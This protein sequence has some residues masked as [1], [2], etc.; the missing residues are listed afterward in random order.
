MAEQQRA[1]ERETGDFVEVL[2]NEAEVTIDRI[3]DVGSIVKD[4]LERKAS[5]LGDVLQYET[6]VGVHAIQ[7]AE[8]K[9]LQN[10][11]GLN[12]DEQTSFKSDL[13]KGLIVYHGTNNCS[14][15]LGPCLNLEDSGLEDLYLWP[16]ISRVILQSIHKDKTSKEQT[17]EPLSNLE[18]LFSSK[19][20]IFL[21]ADAGV[22]KTSFCKFLVLS[23]CKV[24]EGTT[25]LKSTV[26]GTQSVS[27]I[28]EYLKEFTYLFYINLRENQCA[29]LEDIIFSH[30]ESVDTKLT[31]DNK[32]FDNILSKENGLFILDGLDECKIPL[33][34]SMPVNRKYTV[35]ITSRPWK[36]ANISMQKKYTHAQIEVMKQ[37]LSKQLVNHANECLNKHFK[38]SYDTDDFL[39]AVKTQ[40]LESQLEN[41]MFALQLLC[42]YHDK[43]SENKTCSDNA[44]VHRLCSDSGTTSVPRQTG[45]TYLGKT[46]SH[47]YANMIELMLRSTEKK[48]ESLVQDLSEYYKNNGQ[49]HALPEC[50]DERN[51]AC[52]G[53]AKLIYAIGKLAAYSLL[54]DNKSLIEEHQ[55][56]KLKKDETSV[57]LKSGLLSKTSLKTISGESN[58]YT[59]LHQ[60]Y[61]EMLACVFLSS[62]SFDSDIWRKFIENFGSVVSPDML[63]FLC[64]MNYEQGCKCVDMFNESKRLFVR[65]GTFYTSE[66]IAYQTTIAMTHK[67]CFDNGIKEP[68]ITLKH[69]LLNPDSGIGT[70]HALLHT[71]NPSSLE[72]FWVAVKPELIQE[73]PPMKLSFVG[74]SQFSSNLKKLSLVHVN[75]DVPLDLANCP[76]LQKLVMGNTSSDSVT[77]ICVVRSMQRCDALQELQL[78]TLTFPADTHLDL[79]GLIH[80]S[81]I[82][83]QDTRLSRVTIN[84]SSLE[85]FWVAVK[86]E[87]IQEIPPMKL[88]FVGGSQFSSNLKKL[89]L[90]H[91]N[92]DV[93]LDLAN[94]PQLQKLVMGNTSSDS[95]TG[96]CV[97]RSMQRCDA[98]QELQLGTLTFPADTH[99]DLS[100]LTHLSNITIQDTRLSRVTINPSSLEEFC[101]YVKPEL[102]QEIPPMKLSFVG[103]SQFSSNLKKLSLVHVNMDVPLDLANCPQLQKLVMGNTSSDSVTGICVVRS[104][105]R[106][107]ALQKLQLGTLTF[108]ADTHLDLSGLTHLSNITIQHTRLSH[109]TIN[110]SCLEMFWVAVKPELIQEIPPVKLSFVGGSQF[111]SNLKKLS[112][113]HVNMDVPLDLANCPQ[114]QE[115]VM[116]NTSSDSVTG[117]CVVRSMQR[118]D[119]LQ[120][121]Q[122]DTLTFPADTHLDL[123]GLTH[124]SNITIQ[125]TRLSRVTI[126]PSS[127]EEF[128]VYVKPELIQEIPPMKLSFVGGSQFSSNLKKLSLVHVNMDVPLDLANCPQ[129]QELV[130]ENTSS[131]SVTGICVVRSMQRCD[132]LQKLRLDTLTFPADTHLDL[133]G[134]THLSNITIQHTRLSHVTINP[135]CLE[136]FWV[137]VK[138]ELIQ[139]I[140]PVKLSFVGGSQ[141]S[142]N[143]KKLSLVHVNMDVPL[144]LANCPQLQKLVMENTS[145]D[146]V[147]GI[148]VVRSM[149]RCDALQEL[150]L[151]TLTFPADTHLDLSGLTH[152]SN[153]TIQDTRLS[154]VTINPSSLE[155]FCVYVK[156]E[157]IQEI[158]PM[159]L[160][161]VGGSQFSSNLKKL[162]L[163][164]VNM[165]VPLDLANCPQLQELVMENTSSDS[166]TGICVVRSMQRCDALQ[167]LRLDTLTFPADTHLD[168]SG[169]T[170]LS[171]ITIQHTRLSHV[172]INPSCLEVLWVAV[173]PELIQEIPPVKLSFVGGSQFSSNLKKLSLVHVNMDVPL[174]LANCPQ[175][176]KLVM[177]NTSSDSVTGICVVRSMQRCDALQ[178]LRLDT[179]TFPADTHLDLSGFTHLSSITIQDTR[180]SRITIN[181]SSLEEFGVYVRPE[182]IQEIPPMKLS[183][184]GGSQFSSNLK[185]L[186]LVHVTMDVPLDLAN[187]PQLQQV[188]GNTSS[189]SVTGI[190]VVRSM[191]RCDA[192]H[193]LHLDTLTFPA[194]T[195]LD[196]SGLTHI[197]NIAIQNTRLSRVTINPSSLEKF[198]VY[199][200]PELIQEI[201]PVKLSFVGGSQFSSN[202]KKL[203]LVHVTM[204]VPLDLAN[205]P[206]LQQLVMENTSS[207]SVTGICVVRSMQRCDALQKL[208]LNTLTFPADTHLDLSELTCLT[209]ISLARLKTN[210]TVQFPQNVHKIVIDGVTFRKNTHLDLSGLAH[211]SKITIQNTRLSHV[212]INPSSLEMFWVYVRPEMRQEIP[213]MKVSFVGGLQ[214][215][216]NLKELSLVNVTMDVP[217]DLANCQQLHDL[218]TENTSSDSVTGICVVRSMQRCDALQKLQLNTLTFPADTH[219]DLS[220]LTCLTDISLARLK[221]NITVQFPQNVH[222][223]FIDGVI[224]RTNTHLDLSGLAHLSKI[225]IQNIRLSRVTINPSCLEEFWVFVKPELKQEIPSMKLSFVGGS[226][227]PSNLK[228]LSLVHVIMDAPLDLANC[229]Q[230]QKLVMENTSSDSVTDICVV[231]NMQRCDALQKLRLDTLT[232][233]A[234]THLDLSELTCLTDISL[235]TLMT[236][237]TIQFPQNVHKIFIDG[238]TFRKNT[239]LDLSG[240]AHLSKITIQNTR[241][242]RVT[243]NPSSLEMFWVYVR[244]EM[245]QEI[246][247]MKVSFVSGSKFSS[248]LTMLSLVHT[249]SIHSVDLSECVQLQTLRTSHILQIGT[250]GLPRLEEVRLF[251]AQTEVCNNVLQFISESSCPCG[252]IWFENL[253]PEIFSSLTVSRTY[254]EKLESFKFRLIYFDI[255]VFDFIKI[256]GVKKVEFAKVKI[257]K[258]QQL[259]ALLTSTEA[260][261]A[262][263]NTA[264]GVVELPVGLR[265]SDISFSDCPVLGSTV[266]ELDSAIECLR[267]VWEIKEVKIE[268]Q[269]SSISNTV[270]GEDIISENHIVL[271]SLQL[272]S[273]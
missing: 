48:E 251:G 164:H 146:S 245:I 120:E 53:L 7:D 178:K 163:V 70:D 79:S 87:L 45:L 129:L 33:I 210:I 264:G 71:I 100:G 270:C 9:A 28:I 162:S 51:Y 268:T 39:D 83:I 88:S 263:D 141:F 176:Q 4:E 219:L 122:L 62:H 197:S 152:L 201:P 67:E 105:Q 43:R 19:G 92:M 237:I 20:I 54:G 112:L 233:P 147:T 191:Q 61:K 172:T 187:C 11:K 180:L 77:G 181:P 56:R 123:S 156:P 149:Q 76:Q 8:D 126:N 84:P 273:N 44:T 138:P 212:T 266:E 199:V 26:S 135:S 200:K 209:D 192:L 21:T 133:S 155:E 256:T 185:K 174:D 239:H 165:D 267:R 240:L 110:P 80:L 47:V 134:L 157:L 81:N 23:W 265:V 189:D 249:T 193:T 14:L 137:A 18:Q 177:E 30:T 106:C 102:I 167:K 93:P 95:V 221:T 73:I 226:Q 90:V 188:M 101:V 124:L 224:F 262:S 234:D 203:S 24:Q 37:D 104:M 151:G 72:M 91:V 34:M 139:E 111:S 169:L 246:P 231:R 213:P 218:G 60:T 173:K 1:L 86:P 66:L 117:I 46:R 52:C 248:K 220:E 255:N 36:L 125:D 49:P 75:M 78:D 148:C 166:V 65:D 236:N 109:V 131:D 59:F 97:V 74:G 15:P 215:S 217:L 127:L 63:S 259:V 184:V 114:L 22:G 204:D 17:T 5:V 130:M 229:H 235:I 35:L 244:P 99:L 25:D 254:T 119:A 269:Q 241:L 96:I 171:N 142:S 170:N 271:K 145:S 168:L 247:P 68:R 40:C 214:F 253:S 108:P 58:V 10:I 225:T 41:P 227:F 160:S 115:L 232:F 194:D 153:I 202:L 94:C 128:C 238:V 205:C 144:D 13:K 161:F 195:H 150:Q 132:A 175:L 31:R 272:N 113:V 208:Q 16:N 140:P 103:G 98:L 136:M 223:I 82:T 258:A 211:L 186:S 12:E 159:K 250:L 2:E 118:C 207:D 190:C 38:T 222:E 29:K 116:G 107:D 69:A 260:I 183:F 64:V 85:M 228:E 27:S 6:D 143:L 89:S 55:I 179:L 158:P 121:L 243:I 206:Q 57:L 42:I 242:S 182:M 50:F 154:R 32:A 216:S 257:V 261:Q 3:Q 230:L 198:C 196:L 252:R